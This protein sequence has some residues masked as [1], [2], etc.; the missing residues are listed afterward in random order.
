[1]G[2]F[3]SFIGKNTLK[4]L[5][6]NRWSSDDDSSSSEDEVEPRVNGNIIGSTD[7]KKGKTSLTLYTILKGWDAVMK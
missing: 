4:L 7:N 1:M 2:Y 3:L 6:L 5:P